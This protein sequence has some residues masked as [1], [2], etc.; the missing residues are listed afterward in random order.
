MI[1]LALRLNQSL[2]S[3][4]LM[5]LKWVRF[6]SEPVDTES[7]QLLYTAIVICFG[8]HHFQFDL[9]TFV[10]LIMN[11]ET[12]WVGYDRARCADVA[13]TTPITSL[14]PT[15]SYPAQRLVNQT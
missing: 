1:A 15:A 6:D 5:T 2:I 9:R 12:G 10:I 11:L 13:R 7:S 3:S 4:A 14:E 8:A